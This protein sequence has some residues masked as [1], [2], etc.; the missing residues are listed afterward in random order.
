VIDT[1]KGRGDGAAIGDFKMAK[2]GLENLARGCNLSQFLKAN[3]DVLNSLSKDCPSYMREPLVK[4]AL[5]TD[6]FKAVQNVYS[7]SKQLFW[8]SDS[9]KTE[10]A[11]VLGQYDS[12]PEFKAKMDLAWEILYKNRAGGKIFKEQIDSLIGKA[13][14]S[15]TSEPAGPVNAATKATESTGAAK[16]VSS[17]AAMSPEPQ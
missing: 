16:R 17:D 5:S 10:L 4:S 7:R 8:L 13:A 3:P 14:A 15:T 1:S 11:Q 2:E 6:D 9:N 12:N